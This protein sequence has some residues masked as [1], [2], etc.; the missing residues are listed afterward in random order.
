MQ[1]EIPPSKPPELPPDFL[2][3]WDAYGKKGSRRESLASWTKLKPNPELAA[4]VIAAAKKYRAAH[5]DDPQFQKDGQRW[6]KNEGWNDEIVPRKDD[7]KRTGIW[8]QDYSPENY[9]TK[10]QIDEYGFPVSNP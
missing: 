2:E 7:T 5:T 10:G 4:E 8:A 9:A 6:L 1:G 3:F